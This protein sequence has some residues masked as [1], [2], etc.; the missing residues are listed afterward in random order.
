MAWFITLA[1]FLFLQSA[2]AS[3]RIGV[4][5]IEELILRPTLTSIEDQ[6]EE[7]SL[8]DSSFALS[9]RRDKNLSARMAVGS[10]LL[11]GMPIYYSA[12][13]IEDNLGFYEAYAEYSGFFGSFRFGLIPLN[14]GYDG[15]ISEA[16]RYYNR[17]QPYSQRLVGLRDYGMSFTTEHRGYYTQLTA[18]NGEV[19]STSDGRL[20][21]S[22]NW[23]YTNRRNIRAQM[24]LQTGTVKGNSSTTA[25]HT[26]GGVINGET[27][28]W[29]HGAI[30]VNWYPRNW[31]VV[32]QSYGGEVDQNQQ[33]GRFT[34]NMFELTR[35]FSKNFGAGVRYDLFDPNHDISGDKITEASLL[36]LFKSADSTSDFYLL[37]TKV[38]EQSNEVPNDQL[39]LVWL[40]TPFSR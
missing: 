2:A 38:Y 32:V 11:R 15:Q 12:A 37:G 34:G 8:S 10:E 26:T 3:E 31:N 4:F 21:V 1:L 6:G 33:T 5:N 18:H 36:L 25:T 16:D 30:F 20:W 27:A 13:A 35:Y 9:W 7:F 23:G 14:F 19:D 22:G 39:R 24:S 40:L 28:K 29:R 17:A